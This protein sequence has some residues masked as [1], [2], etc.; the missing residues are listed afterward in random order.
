MQEDKHKRFETNPFKVNV[1]KYS[2]L[3]GAKVVDRDT[4][5]IK[6]Y[7]LLKEVKDSK[8]HTKV[9]NLFYYKSFLLKGEAVLKV[10]NYIQLIT[11]KDS[12][13]VVMDIDKVCEVT[14]ISRSSYT[15]CIKQL[16]DND[17]IRKAIGV[18]KYWINAELFFNGKRESNKGKD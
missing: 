9:Y 15:G 16:I 3:V 8:I 18:N 17:I 14:G 11:S 6:N 13:Y 1:H 4:G 2:I 10:A 12:D 7:E 5:E